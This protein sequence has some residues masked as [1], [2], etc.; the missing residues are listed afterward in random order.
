MRNVKNNIAK[1]AKR[2]H[3]NISSVVNVSSY[4]YLNETKKNVLILFRFHLS[5]YLKTEIPI[6]LQRNLETV[7]G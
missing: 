6:R 2:C 7:S 5:E 1:I 4:F 3:E